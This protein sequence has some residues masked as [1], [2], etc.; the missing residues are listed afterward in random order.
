[1]LLRFN[2]SYKS[3]NQILDPEEGQGGKGALWLGDYTA[4][5][6]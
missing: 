5:I 3:M 1:M 6:N 2:N 4:A